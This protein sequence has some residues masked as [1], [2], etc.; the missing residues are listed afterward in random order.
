MTL[1]FKFCYPCLDLMLNPGVFDDEGCSG[2]AQ[3]VDLCGHL[4]QS[5][6]HNSLLLFSHFIIHPLLLC[7]TSHR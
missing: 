6:D 5:L 2:L 3:V 4:C 1:R 7:L